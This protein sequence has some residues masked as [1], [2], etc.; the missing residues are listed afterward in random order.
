MFLLIR[1]ME[2]DIAGHVELL[3]ICGDIAGLI[4]TNPVTHQKATICCLPHVSYVR[5]LSGIPGVTGAAHTP[6]LSQPPS[7]SDHRH[8]LHNNISIQLMQTQRT[9]RTRGYSRT[10]TLT[11]LRLENCLSN[12][13]D[14]KYSVRLKLP[15]LTDWRSTPPMCNST[16]VKVKKKWAFWYS[17]TH[18]NQLGFI[19]YC[20]GK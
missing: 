20:L 1:T 2:A 18:S 13:D 8:S 16:K 7:I 19:F 5:F 12:L 17:L 15:Q 6:P 4:W 3:Y 9:Q 14:C 11:G 10:Q